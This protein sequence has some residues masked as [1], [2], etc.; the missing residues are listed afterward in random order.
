[1]G[2]IAAAYGYITADDDP[3]RWGADL[4]AEDT[5]QLAQLVSKAVN[6]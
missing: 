2:T 1:M 3:G 5:D 6:L 4:I